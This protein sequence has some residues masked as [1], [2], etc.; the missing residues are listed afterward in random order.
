MSGPEST[1]WKSSSVAIA[2]QEVGMERGTV[3]LPR[4]DVP[5]VVEGTAGRTCLVYSLLE[6]HRRAFS[7]RFKHG[8][9]CVFV[10]ARFAIP[11]AA[12]DPAD[13]FTVDAA[14]ED[15]EAV[16]AALGLDRFVLVGHSIQGTIALA[17]AMRYP[18]H[19]THVVA[20]APIPE[21]TPAWQ[22]A[23]EEYWVR[24]ASAA[25]KALHAEKR[26]AFTEELLAAM[27]PHEAV[28]ADTVADGPKRWHDAG[29]DEGPLLSLDRFNVPVAMQLFGSEYR[30]FRGDARIEPPVFLA[31][32]R[33]DFA[34]PWT[35]W[36]PHRDRFRDLTL[37][38]FDRSGHTPQ[39]E[40]A[41]E[42]DARVGAWLAS[43]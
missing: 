36:P 29:Y 7:D 27:A 38:L 30:L 39:V 15:I 43:R 4:F 9:R 21:V 20:I 13:P 3:K 22:A 1:A 31:L 5:F 12:A 6:Y 40:Q 26:A 14:V 42:F 2:G 37:E 11:A 35:L 41:E 19:V 28:V 18:R 24:E 34:A 32:G 8:M 33:S 10:Q 25:R 17:Y 16:R 23:A